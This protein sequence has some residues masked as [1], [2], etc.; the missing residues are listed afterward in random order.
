MMSMLESVKYSYR[1]ADEA[2]LWSVVF[3]YIDLKHIF[4]ASIFRVV[5]EYNF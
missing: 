4:F 2:L 1:D 3:E 5:S